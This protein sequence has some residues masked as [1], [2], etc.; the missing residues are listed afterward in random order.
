MKKSVLP[1]RL[2]LIAEQIDP[3][4]VVADI[5]TDHGLVP[6]EA[7][8]HRKAERAVAAD[9]NAGPLQA[10]SDYIAS[11]GLTDKID[12]RLGSGLAVLTK[13]DAVDTVVIAGMGGTLI[14]DILEQGKIKLH[15]V[16]KLV[17]QPNVSAVRVRKW[18][19]D[20]G[21]KLT[22]E[23]ILKEERHVYEVLTAVPGEAEAPYQEC[24][25]PLEKQLLFGPYLLEERNN[26]FKEKWMREKD[27]W[28]QILHQ[29]T[30]AVPTEKIT[31]KKQELSQYIAWVEEVI[32]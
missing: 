31:A 21:W 4:A 10:A 11:C 17:L 28:Q 3:G 22:G 2:A 7:V 16:Q 27:N 19:L 14:A 24:G 15:F 1:D 13:K 32:A 20:N 9:V 26:A 25:E 29:L 8:A 5:G 12:I 30:N 23:R 18:L 6:V